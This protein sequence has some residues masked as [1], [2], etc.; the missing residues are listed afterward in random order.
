M[1]F[2]KARLSQ[3]EAVHEVQGDRKST[4][5]KTRRTRRRSGGT[6]LMYEVKLP[7]RGKSSGTSLP[8]S[9]VMLQDISRKRKD[10]NCVEK[11][12]WSGTRISLR[13]W[14]SRT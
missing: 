5:T 14:S 4:E 11:K 9:K 10:V 12:T 8:E 1:N 13:R 2:E 7:H 6:P 3:A